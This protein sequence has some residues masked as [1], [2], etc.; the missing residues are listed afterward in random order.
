[1]T[2]TSGSASPSPKN[3]RH[4]ILDILKREG[5]Q[6]ARTLARRLSVTPM[7]IGLQLASLEEEKVVAP[8]AE[9]AREPRRGRPVRLWRLTEAANRAF[10]DAH[11]LL[12][13]GLLNSL[14]EVYGQK[15]IEKLLEARTRQHV[16]EYGRSM[17]EG[18]LKEKVKALAALRDREGYMTEVKAAPGGGFLLIENHCPICTAAKTC[19]G[20][21]QS[22]WKVFQNLMGKDAE[23][24]REE[25]LLSGDRRCV[26]SIRPI[27]SVTAAAGTTSAA[28][29]KIGGVI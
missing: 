14:H 3:T 13:V 16:D 2:Q 19:Q 17:P 10:P 18:N 26:Y 12:T 21:C 29:T 1:M 25:H 7:A 23:V 8:E 28:K 4:T 9:T 24:T 27:P 15:G 11:A 5:P 6:D 20:I 22:E